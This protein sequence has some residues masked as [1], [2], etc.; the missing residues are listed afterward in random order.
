MKRKLILIGILTIALVYLCGCSKPATLAD[1]TQEQT[2]VFE[3]LSKVSVY[4][5]LQVKYE[6]ITLEELCT[7]Q[8][9]QLVPYVQE[10]TLPKNAAELFDQWRKEN[11]WDALF[12]NIDEK[13]SLVVPYENIKNPIALDEVTVETYTILEIYATPIAS[14][15]L[16]VKNGEKTLEEIE[17]EHILAID[18]MI[19]EEYIPENAQY[20][21]KE[22]KEQ[23]GYYEIFANKENLVVIDGVI[24]EKPKEV[25]KPKPAQPNSSSQSSQSVKSWLDAEGY[26]IRSEEEIYKI[27]GQTT[28]PA[29]E[30]NWLA[31]LI[32]EEYKD[33]PYLENLLKPK[34]INQAEEYFLMTGKCNGKLSVD[35]EDAGL[36]N[37]YERALDA[38]AKSIAKDWNVSY[39]E[40]MEYILSDT[41]NNI[42][43]EAGQYSLE[44]NISYDDAI[45]MFQEKTA[46]EYFN[47]Q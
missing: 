7:M 3:E 15:F 41:Y 37:S 43:D 10:K 46:R 32:R 17:A 29:I 13:S 33:N 6:R 47:K 45:R 18:K 14:E 28:R 22:L 26:Y 21:L 35:A 1:L 12:E 4:E 27:Y 30:D 24:T 42:W 5:F 20:L 44:H 25:P 9:E 11:H 2:A 34:Y 23:E 19:L 8:N 31:D 40:A 39:E 36:G 16:T 38:R